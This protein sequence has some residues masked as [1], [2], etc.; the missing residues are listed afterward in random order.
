[1]SERE[2]AIGALSV[3]DNDFVSMVWNFIQETSK[4]INNIE[5]VSI[6]DPDLTPEEIQAIEAY[7]NGDAEYQPTI[8]L[9]SLK[10]E[11]GL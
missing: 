2:R 8:S 4:R 6:N 5:L 9:S 11:L 1:M 10:S 7:K 3:M